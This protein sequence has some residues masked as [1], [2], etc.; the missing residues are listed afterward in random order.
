MYFSYLF[1]Y[2]K[3]RKNKKNGIILVSL[4]HLSQ[5]SHIDF[6]RKKAFHYFST[7]T[8]FKSLYEGK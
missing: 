6:Y 4:T 3:R 2:R 1:A 7:H 8:I 5:D